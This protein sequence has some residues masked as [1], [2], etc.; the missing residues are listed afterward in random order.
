VVG[1]D[2]FWSVTVRDPNT[3]D[4]TLSP[5]TGKHEAL[6]V[7]NRLN[8]LECGGTCTVTVTHTPGKA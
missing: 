5:Y 8:Q 2:G 1:N 3:G 4:D 6:E 7:G